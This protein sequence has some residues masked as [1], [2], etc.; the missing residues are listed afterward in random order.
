MDSHIVTDISFV[1]QEICSFDWDPFLVKS[2]AA[3]RIDFAILYKTQLKNKPATWTYCCFVDF[4]IVRDI[5]FFW[6]EIY[7]CDWDPILWQE[8]C[9]FSRKS[10]LVTGNLFLWPEIYS[11]DKKFILVTGNIFFWQEIYSCDR[12]FILVTGR[13]FLRHESYSCDTQGCLSLF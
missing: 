4:H 8:N 3:N 6:Q 9:S 10:I 7:S 11:C 5:S 2:L 12:K 13:F 1:W